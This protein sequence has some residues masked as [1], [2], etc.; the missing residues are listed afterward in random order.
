MI[1]GVLQLWRLFS[2][3]CLDDLSFHDHGVL[4]CCNDSV[5]GALFLSLGPLANEIQWSNLWYTC[6]YNH[7]IILAEI[8]FIIVALRDGGRRIVRFRSGLATWNTLSQNKQQKYRFSLQ[9][10]SPLILVLYLSGWVPLL[11]LP[12]LPF[13]YNLCI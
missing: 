3:I 2:S 9:S 5:P 13:S 8:A 12:F 6:V 4:K 10:L 11:L 1:L 7:Y